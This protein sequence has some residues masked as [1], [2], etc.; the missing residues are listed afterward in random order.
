MPSCVSVKLSQ[1]KL[2][3]QRSACINR[4]ISSYCG[5]VKPS[6]LSTNTATSAHQF[7]PSFCAAVVKR[8]AGSIALLAITCSYAA[9]KS[10]KS[11]I[12]SRSSSGACVMAKSASGVAP[13]IFSSLSASAAKRQK[14]VLRR[15]RRYVFTSSPR[16]SSARR[17]ATTR[18]ASVK[19]RTLTPPN[20][21]KSCS[22]SE[23][24]LY[25]SQ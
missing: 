15:W 8:S 24:K 20:S 3:T 17:T 1:H 18:A 7:S 9:Y 2:T 23:V 5:A 21:R 25:T 11:R 10:P 6:K 22:A 16:L 13:A 12:F 14:P 19:V 4:R